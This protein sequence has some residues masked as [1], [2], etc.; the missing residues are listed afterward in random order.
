MI[1]RYPPTLT[2][3]IFLGTNDLSRTAKRKTLKEVSFTVNDDCIEDHDDG[4]YG[5]ATCQTYPA[6]GINQRKARNMRVNQ[7]ERRGMSNIG[8]T[9][10]NYYDI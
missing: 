3:S 1:Y 2:L 4:S 5:H 8:I 6:K 7:E 10:N 9:F